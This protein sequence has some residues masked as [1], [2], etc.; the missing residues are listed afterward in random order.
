MRENVMMLSF[1][2]GILCFIV[3][4]LFGIGV[5]VWIT[6]DV[7]IKNPV[8]GVLV[9]IVLTFIY[10]CIFLVFIGILDNIHDKIEYT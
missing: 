4:M 1:L 2:M 8:A 6:M 10:F 7:F 9:G 3:Y 5:L